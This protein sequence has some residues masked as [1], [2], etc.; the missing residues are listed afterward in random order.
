MKSFSF[1]ITFAASNKS[2]YE[3]WLRALA[4]LKDETEKRKKE[5]AKKQQIKDSIIV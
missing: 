3:S 5:I 2:D 4:K 1:D